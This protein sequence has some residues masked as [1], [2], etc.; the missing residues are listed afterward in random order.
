MR[1]RMRLI[2][3]TV[4]AAVCVGLTAFWLTRPQF[5]YEETRLVTSAG[6]TILPCS[7]NDHGQIVGFVLRTYGERS[8]IESVYLWDQ[9]EGPRKLDCFDNYQHVSPASFKINNACQLAGAIEDPNGTCRAFLWDPKSG[10]QLLDTLGGLKSEA[11]AINDHG[12]AAGYSQTTSQLKHAVLWSEDTGVIDIGTLGGPESHAGSMNNKGQ[13]VGF[14]QV[15]S[16]KWHAFFWDPNTGMKD[17][18][19]TSLMWPPG[20]CLHINNNGLIVGRFGSA[21]DE[22]L[23]ST[24]SAGGGIGSM[25]SPQGIDAIPWA[26]NDADQFFFSVRSRLF[27]GFPLQHELYLWVPMQ[28]FVS[29]DEKIN[30]NRASRL[31]LMDVNNNGQIVGWFA[32]GRSEK[33]GMVLNPIAAKRNQAIEPAR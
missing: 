17:I 8:L 14:S 25:P 24:W 6:E 12:H 11:W 15:A 27:K 22:M 26:L 32:R 20:H 3:C 30:Y 31:S 16:G 21:T 5:L 2:I 33:Y 23:I 9:D 7:I 29:L 28:S 13:V 1:R 19:P 10:L 4:A 18:G